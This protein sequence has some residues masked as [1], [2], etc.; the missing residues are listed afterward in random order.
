VLSSCWQRL[1]WRVNPTT[2][3]SIRSWMEC[4]IWRQRGVGSGT[5]SELLEALSATLRDSKLPRTTFHLSGVLGMMAGYFENCGVRVE[6]ETHG[7]EQIVHLY[8]IEWEAVPF[9]EADIPVIH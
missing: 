1:K 9:G 4:A 5:V 7:G 3:M 8:L 2:R 6:L